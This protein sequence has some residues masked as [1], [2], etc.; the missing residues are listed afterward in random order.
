M[1]PATSS[2]PCSEIAASCRPAIQPSVRV[3][4]AA[5][6][7]AVRFRP[8]T[9]LRKSAASDGVKRRS[10]ARSSVNWPRA[11]NRA[12]GSAGSSRVAMTRCTW[13]GRCSTR[14][15]RRIVDRL[16][17][18][19]VVVVENEHDIARDGGDVVE[20]GRQR[21][22]EWRGLAATGERS[23]SL[24]QSRAQPSAEPRSDRSESGWG[25]CRLH[26]AI[27]TPPVARSPR[28][29][30]RPAWSCQSRR[31]LRPGS[32]CCRQRG[33]RSAARPVAGGGRPVAA[34]VGCRA[35]W[36]GSPRAPI[37]YRDGGGGFRDGRGNQN[38]RTSA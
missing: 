7:S 24:R 38:R 32:A 19:D 26:R 14:K 21:R 11:R 8:I 10:A 23:I 12:R 3:S 2:R 33:L 6:S 16:G 13:G 15:A 35:W 18:E 31:E 36:P 25:R 4:R 37:N 5:M 1:K 34:R 30:R 27:A 20:Q 22:L 28:P 17:V 9:W 29:I